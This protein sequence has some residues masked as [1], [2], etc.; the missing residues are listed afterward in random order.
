MGPICLCRDRPVSIHVTLTRISL[1]HR[2]PTG[3]RRRMRPTPD[4]A[5]RLEPVRIAS[6]ELHE[7][8]H[9]C[10]LVETIDEIYDVLDS[11]I[12]DGFAV[13]DR[14]FHI[15]DPDLVLGHVERLRADG[16]DTASAEA[17]RQL[18][19]DTWSDSYLRGGRFDRIAQLA[20][21]RTHLNEGR[22]LGYPRTRLIA[23]MEWAIDGTVL[24]DLV[25]YE[26]NLGAILRRT[27]DVVVCAYD[28]TRH[29][30]RTIAEVLRVHPVSVVGGFL[31]IGEGPSTRSARDRLLEAAARLF[32]EA[33]IQASGVDSIVDAAGVAK[34]TFYRHFPSKDDLVV[35]WLQDPHTRWID[36][37]RREVEA[38]H[39]QPADVIPLFFE[40]LADWLETE[41]Y[42]GCPYLNTA[43]EIADPGHP[44][45]AVIRDYLEE[46][47][48][49]LAGLAQSAGYRDPA[50]IGA[51]LHL[52]V[53]GS[54]TLAV[55][56]RTGAFAL[57][58]REAARVLLAGAERA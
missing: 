40:A 28:L 20:Y 19:V 25:A 14:A 48:D 11:F 50:M 49:Y 13:G 7:H 26:A 21:M 17:V 42:R 2:P 18:Q 47:E 35:A 54:I 52:L 33:G 44:A 3:R 27:P 53:A 6:A 31:R 36:R 51:E 16:I 29:S 15:V 45:R 39:A 22:P 23:T 55:A 30:A 46:I 5:T 12:A 8:R 58:A 4:V 57:T 24:R 37:V 1:A 38:H 43:V 9:V 56:R 34:A 32:H 41:G 10:L